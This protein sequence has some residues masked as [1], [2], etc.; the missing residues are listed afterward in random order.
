M[1]SCLDPL[2]ETAFRLRKYTSPIFEYVLVMAEPGPQQADP[3][4]VPALARRRC[5]LPSV[6]C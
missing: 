3:L 6:S 1:G 4:G 5:G 2:L